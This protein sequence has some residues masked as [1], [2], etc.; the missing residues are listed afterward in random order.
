MPLKPNRPFQPGD[1]VYHRSA[2]GPIFVR[3]VER[4]TPTGIA[5]LD[6]GT[7]IGASGKEHGS[8]GNWSKFWQH[9]TPEVEAQ[10]ALGAAQRRAG[11]RMTNVDLRK[12]TLDQCNA[13]IAILENV[14]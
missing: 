12:L 4:V 11:T 5:V 7:K 10:D 2:H 9:L 3:T 8:T 14:K 6:N 1:R 13:L